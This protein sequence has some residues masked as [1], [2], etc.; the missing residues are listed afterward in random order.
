M[1]SYA[2]PC[3]RLQHSH[4]QSEHKV[5]TERIAKA[6]SYT[7]AYEYVTKFYGRKAGQEPTASQAVKSG[8]LSLARIDSV[9]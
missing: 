7:T 3:S 8:S 1:F 4:S 6:M 9:S 2:G 5:R